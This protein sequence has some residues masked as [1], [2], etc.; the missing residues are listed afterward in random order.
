MRGDFAAALRL[1]AAAEKRTASRLAALRA[2][3]EIYRR[4]DYLDREIATLRR[5]A[6]LAPGDVDTRLRLVYICLDLGWWREAA[7]ASAAAIQRAPANPRAQVARAVVLYRSPAPAAAIPFARQAV[8]LAPD[9]PEYQNL[10]ATILIKSRQ[11]A[12]AEAVLRPA[13]AKDPADRSNHLA[14]A[15]ALVKQNRLPEAEAEYRE[16]LKREPAQMDAVYG[17][18]D[19]AEVQGRLDDAIRHFEE[20]A[21]RD[22]SY[23]NV[24]WR[25]GRLDMKR[26]RKKEG[27]DLIATYKKMEAATSTYENALTRLRSR[28]QDAGLHLTLAQCHLDVGELPQAIAEFR[29]VLEMRPKD[30]AA[31][32]DLARALAAAGRKTEAA[33]IAM[34]ESVPP[35]SQ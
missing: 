11:F 12:E 23:A 20:I 14:L 34:A 3:V 8:R 13:L 31:R 29:R 6:A 32:R 7:D 24:A 21:R 30:M 15:S 4:A 2:E 33:T 18:A 16:I 35:G 22:V 19:V 9:R 27:A 28:P 10:L 25:L 17:L 26:G 1:C 5:I